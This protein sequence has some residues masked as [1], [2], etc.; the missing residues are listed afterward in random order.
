MLP[1]QAKVTGEYSGRIEPPARKLT[2]FRVSPPSAILN[3]SCRG[4]RR[5][6]SKIPEETQRVRERER[7]GKVSP[8]DDHRRC[9]SRT[10]RGNLLGRRRLPLR[11]RRR[12][13]SSRPRG[14]GSSCR[15]RCWCWPSSSAMFS[16]ATRYTTSRRPAP[17]FSSVTQPSPSLFLIDSRTNIVVDR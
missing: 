10:W 17:P 9:W 14:W 13:R 8:T 16:A 1:A 2:I 4:C 3:L 7:E 5:R 11:R 6:R 12:G 15:S